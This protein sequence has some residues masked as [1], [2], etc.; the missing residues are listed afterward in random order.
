MYASQGEVADL[1][2]EEG[3]IWAESGQFKFLGLGQT[4]HDAPDERREREQEEHRENR[5]VLASGN[6]E[7]V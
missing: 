5:S 4:I 6:A 3:Q 2:K 7:I 1:R